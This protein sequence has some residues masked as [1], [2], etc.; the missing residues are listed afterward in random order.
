[1][2]LKKLHI[3]N[4][5]NLQDIAIDFLCCNGTTLLVGNNG[6]GKSNILEA[7]SSIFARLY[8]DRIHKPNFDYNI[9]YEINGHNIDIS[10]KA[11]NYSILVDSKSINKSEFSADSNNLPSN[12]IACYSGES[13]RLWDNFYWSYYKDYIGNI[14]KTSSIPTLPLVYINKYV[15]EFALIVLFFFNFDE[16]TD[17]ATFCGETLGIKTVRNITFDFNVAKIKGWRENAIV[18]FA[19]RLCNVDTIAKIPS[20]ITISLDDFKDRLSYLQSRERDIFYYFFGAFM[21]K[22]DKIITKIS[23]DLELKDDSIIQVDDLSEGEKKNILIMTILEVLADEN[24]L[25]LLDE[26]DAHIH[27]SRKQ[28]L[29]QIISKYDNRESIWTTHSPTLASAFEEENNIIGL[30]LDENNKTK[31]IAKPTA[32]LI[33]EITKGIWNIHQQNVFAA[34]TKPITLLVEG[35]TDKIHIQEAYKHLKA[36]FPTLDFDIFAMNSS[37]HIREILI[38]LSCS[39]IQWDK[40]FIGIF[41][42]DSAGKKDIQNGFEK[43][44]TNNIIKHVKNKDGVPTNC[45]Y[46][47]L[48][49]KTTSFEEKEGF[50]IENCYPALRYQEAV[51][52]ALNEKKGHFDN[53]SIDKIAE[54]LK[55]KSKTILADKAKSFEKSD[56]EGFRRIFELIKEIQNL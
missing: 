4:Y 33:A 1:M 37:E 15:L 48:L 6:C 46:A 16:F 35:K 31:I 45:F 34:S 17:I 51:E 50:T 54:D 27:I 55:N 13:S 8:K 38:G 39:E 24:S 26:P 11:G 14:R 5:K 21:P 23:L 41:D 32:D 43:E 18:N 9:I 29:K 7:I 53:L 40:K 25:I 49:P 3:Q 30:G 44:E 36:E 56:F 47:F 52:Q 22:E 20:T 28:E 2:H 10:L 42:N 12:I 19:N